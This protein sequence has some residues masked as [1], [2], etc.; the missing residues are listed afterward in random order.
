MDRKLALILAI[1]VALTLTVAGYIFPRLSSHG[2]VDQF[3]YY[4]YTNGCLGFE[5][6]LPALDYERVGSTGKFVE[7]EK[8]PYISVTVEGTFVT[9]QWLK[10]REIEELSVSALQRKF[11]NQ[12]YSVKATSVQGLEALEV[13]DRYVISVGK[14]N[15]IVTDEN[16]HALACWIIRK[17]ENIVYAILVRAS[18]HQDGRDMMEF[19]KSSFKL[20]PILRMIQ[21]SYYTYT[22]STYRF[23]IELPKLAH[24]GE[25]EKGK[26]EETVGPQ[27][28]ATG[29]TADFRANLGAGWENFWENLDAMVQQLREG[30]ENENYAV[31]K[32]SIGDLEAIHLSGVGLP[33]FV[34]ST[35]LTREGALTQQLYIFSEDKLYLLTVVAD[36]HQIGLEVFEHLKNSFR[37]LGTQ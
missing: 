22:N 24:S 23:E 8:V 32:I 21:L 33:A 37:R 31:Q 7:T 6:S 1:I 2:I 9:R 36:N 14:R 20:L 4:T 27:Y 3:S 15:G 34:G 29:V 12:G 17:D 5:V 28:L 10:S 11:E 30:F 25:Q 26:I 13:E 16:V 35:I 19:V 18:N